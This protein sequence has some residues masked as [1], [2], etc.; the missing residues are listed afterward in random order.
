MT[1]VCVEVDLM[2]ESSSSSSSPFSMLLSCAENNTAFDPIKD[3]IN[4]ALHDVEQGT[5]NQTA[6]LCATN[7]TICSSEVINN[8]SI[9]ALHQDFLDSSIEDIVFD[10]SIGGVPTTVDEP[11]GCDPSPTPVVVNQTV[12][13]RTCPDLCRNTQI[14]K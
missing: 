11:S 12:T 3:M 9:A 8:C 2:T 14:K 5:C 1:D 13:I 4:L 7:F 10:C 6:Q